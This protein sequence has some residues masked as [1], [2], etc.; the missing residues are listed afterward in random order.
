MT[1]YT[2]QEKDSLWKIAKLFPVTVDEIAAANGLKGRQIH[3]IRVGQVLNIPDKE[4][5]DPDTLL[6]VTF[7]GLDST[8]FTP[9]CVRVCCAGREENYLISDNAPLLVPV[10]DHAGG[11]V[12]LLSSLIT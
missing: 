10:D 3:H 7:R 1:K 9:K 2:V 5:E 6:S 8:K 4:R 11:F 12:N